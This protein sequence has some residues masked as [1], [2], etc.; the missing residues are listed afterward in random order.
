MGWT[1]PEGSRVA[2][3]ALLLGYH[4]G[5]DLVYAGKVGTGFSADVL[6]DLRG[7]LEQL[8]V[9]SHRAPRASCLAR[10]CTGCD[11]SWSRRSP[12]PSGRRRASCGTRGSSGCG[13]TRR[14]RT[15]CGNDGPR[16][17]DQ[18]A[19]QGAVPGTTG[20]TK[21]DLATYYD[22]IAEVMLPH[23]RG[24]PVNMQRFPDGI[25]A[26]ASTRRRCP[27]TSRTGCT[28]S[29]RH[30]RTGRSDRSWCMTP[31]A[32]STSPS[33]P[34]SPRTPGCPERRPGPAGPADLRP[35]PLAPDGT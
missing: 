35:G 18:Q 12:S 14:R 28:P 27:R 33:R 10:P 11:P 26:Q 34:A 23:L 32:S 13:R 31:A 4:H 6:R 25:E 29:G 19:G 22:A 8:A 16:R 21:L 1:D 24:R 20:V 5:D 7:R 2:L 3:G 17:R 15:W 9:D 30:R